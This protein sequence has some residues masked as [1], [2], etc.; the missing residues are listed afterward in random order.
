MTWRDE[1]RIMFNFE[2]KESEFAR[3]EKGLRE[4]LR[5]IKLR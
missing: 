2:S 5:S 3:L 1:D 4:S